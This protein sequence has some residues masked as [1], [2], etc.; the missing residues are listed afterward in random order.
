[1]TDTLPSRPLG[2]RSSTHLYRRWDAADALP[3]PGPA[4]RAFPLL[5]V[6]YPIWW[7]LGIAA[8]LPLAVAAVMA[9]DLSRRRTIPVPRGWTLWC[10]FLVWVLLGALLLGADAPSAV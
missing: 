1:M 7:L 9:L 2:A 6:G 8:V 10:L 5:F 4:G 3:G